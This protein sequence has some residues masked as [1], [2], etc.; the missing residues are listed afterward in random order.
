M[1]LLITVEKGLQVCFDRY[2]V[3]RAL[4]YRHED[5]LRVGQME[6][7]D[8]SRLQ[9][10]DGATEDVPLAGEREGFGCRPDRRTRVERAKR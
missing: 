7:R 10:A 8:H 3:A 1:R 9:G 2:G 5:P 6:H 4:G